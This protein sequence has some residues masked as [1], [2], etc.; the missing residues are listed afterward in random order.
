MPRNRNRNQMDKAHLVHDQSICVSNRAGQSNL[1]LVLFF[2]LSLDF[3]NYEWPE[4]KVLWVYPKT[5]RTTMTSGYPAP[6][7]SKILEHRG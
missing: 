7:G 3:I 2:L 4:E 6:H 1:V 5:C